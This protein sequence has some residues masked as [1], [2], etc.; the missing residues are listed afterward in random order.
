MFNLKKIIISIGIIGIGGIVL[1]SDLSTEFET[2]G[3]IA[4][5]QGLYYQQNGEYLQVLKDNKLPTNEKGFVKEKLGKD[6]PLNYVIDVY[7]ND[8]GKG[9][10]I[11]YDD[12]NAFYSIGYGNE[13][14]QRTWTKE[15]SS[16][17][18]STSTSQ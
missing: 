6:L 16:F 18:N 9:Y 10:Q 13:S 7:E 12:K 4:V 14:K 3:E 17:I 5:K 1:A 11:R 15:K 8:K 2:P